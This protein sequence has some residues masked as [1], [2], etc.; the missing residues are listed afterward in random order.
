MT[1]R[2]C[3]GVNQGGNLVDGPGSRQQISP[4]SAEVGQRAPETVPWGD[5][6]RAPRLW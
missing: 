6:H 4:S 1:I 5:T 2:G 3:V